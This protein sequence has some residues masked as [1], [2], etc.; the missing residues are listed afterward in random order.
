[1]PDWSKLNME[2]E[3]LSHLVGTEL[4]GCKPWLIKIKRNV[5]RFG[6]VAVPSA[7]APNVL[8]PSRG[9]M[10]HIYPCEPFISIGIPL[11]S[12]EHFLSTPEGLHAVKS[13]STTL[14]VPGGSFCYIPAG[15]LFCVVFYKSPEKRGKKEAPMEYADILIAPWPMKEI[16]EKTHEST[17]KAMYTWHCE[18]TKEKKTQM[19]RDRTAFLKATMG[20]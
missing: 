5:R 2:K 1:M 11:G 13:N 4:A 12:Y 7:G 20:Q 17:K 10:V 3:T 14:Y 6:P 15:H 8:A 9:V 16:L 19:W 18:Y